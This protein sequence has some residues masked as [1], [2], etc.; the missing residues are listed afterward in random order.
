MADPLSFEQFVSSFWHRV[1]KDGPIPPEH[2]EMTNCWTWEAYRQDD[3]Y[4]TCMMPTLGAQKCVKAHRL[5]FFLVNGYWPSDE[6]DHQCHVRFCCRPDHFKEA[7]RKENANNRA[8]KLCKNGHPLADPNLYYY[9][10]SG[11]TVRRC[12]ACLSMRVRSVA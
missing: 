7:T 11:R 5:A 4:G 6:I 9:Q 10:S 2:P 8:Q 1:N 12:K 3:G